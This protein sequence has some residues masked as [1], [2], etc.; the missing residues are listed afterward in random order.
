MHTSNMKPITSALALLAAAAFS[1]SAHA[2]AKFWNFGDRNP[3]GACN[4][5]FGANGTTVD[6]REQQGNVIHCTQQ[7][8]GSAVDLTLRAYSNAGFVN[9]WTATMN[10]QGGNGVGVYNSQEVRNSTAP[11]HGLDNV[12]GTDMIMLS[13][14]GAEILRTVTVGWTG[15]DGDFSVLR[16]DGAATADQTTV[17]ASTVGVTVSTM[18]TRGWT[19]VSSF[20][21]AGGVD[22]PDATFHLGGNRG[23]S[24]W[25]ISAYDS[26]FGGTLSAGNDSI[27]VLGVTA[28]VSSPG[29]LALAGLALLCAVFVRRRSS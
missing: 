15:T 8:S 7:P 6:T 12:N 10:D 27:K 16:W 2:Q 1:G 29:T 4:G 23:S 26:A 3:S 19:L 24:Y 9:T 22:N 25:L 14:T 18:L 5:T 17:E 20:D 11:D 21:G 13:F 28:A